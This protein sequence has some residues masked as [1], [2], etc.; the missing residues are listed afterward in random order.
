MNFTVEDIKARYQTVEREADRAGRVI[1]TRRLK[2]A[3]RLKISE[4]TSQQNS[5]ALGIMIVAASVCEIDGR[6][7]PFPRNRSELD[8][9]IDALDEEGISTASTL[10]MK[11][12]NNDAD[13]GDVVEAA[14]N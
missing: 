11:L 6:P 1:G 8:S 9:V 14:K 5:D 2:L 4:M 3:E 12:M 7:I 13:K 10:V